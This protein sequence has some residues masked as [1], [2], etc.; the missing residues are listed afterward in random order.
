MPRALNVVGRR[1]GRLVVLN[2]CE[3][4]SGTRRRVE[5][6]C[7]CGTV[8]HV[9]PRELNKGH[10]ASCGC[11]HKERVGRASIRTHTT[12][13]MSGTPEYESWMKIKAR[14]L[15][16]SDRKYPEYG[17]R[18]ITI[19]EM[20]TASFDNFYA[21]MGPRPTPDHTVDR[22]DVD[23][24]YTP[25]NCRWATSKQQSR[26]KRNHRLVEWRGREVPLSQACEEAG[27]NY[28]SALW[29]LNHGKPWMPLPAPPIPHPGDSRE[30]ET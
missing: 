22:I 8:V 13:G 10:T 4:V 19:C 7:D 5:C 30:E 9:E 14:C 20:W 1:F 21:D 27:V 29:R 6:R 26:N 25:E 11:L 17:G 18:G 16:S 15:R 3:P 24:D 12:H 2:N 28:R 23:G